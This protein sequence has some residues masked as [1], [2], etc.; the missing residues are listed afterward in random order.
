MA[1]TRKLFRKIK[2]EHDGSTRLY[3]ISNKLKKEGKVTDEFEIMLSGLTLEDTI[4]L[5]LELASRSMGYLLYG[6][7]LYGALP[8]IAQEATLKYVLSAS[9]SRSEAARVLGVSI[10]KLHKLYLKF[11]LYD[12]FKEQKHN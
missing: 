5:R 3:S 6:L 7:P 2:K 10:P 9:R 8:R 1:W 12:F 11:N 4:G